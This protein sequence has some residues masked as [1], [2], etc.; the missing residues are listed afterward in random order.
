[1]AVYIP[2][3]SVGDYGADIP[4]GRN[5]H[6]RTAT[7]AACNCGRL[8]QHEQ[9]LHSFGGAVELPPPDHEQPQG[10]VQVGGDAPRE[11]EIGR[12]RFYRLLNLRSG[13]AAG[14]RHE[15]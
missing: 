1:M 9:R 3:E 15:F 6:I 5:F 11:L 7:A 8:S 14:A 13:A 10:S 12:D 2:G 4:C